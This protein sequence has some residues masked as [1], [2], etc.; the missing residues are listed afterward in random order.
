MDSLI[1]YE[2]YPC[3]YRR[4]RKNISIQ[5][6]FLCIKKKYVSSWFENTSRGLSIK[7]RMKNKITILKIRRNVSHQ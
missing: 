6:E 5:I 7:V 2:I 1:K 4:L 3:F